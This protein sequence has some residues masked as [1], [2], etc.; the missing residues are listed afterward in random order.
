[1]GHGASAQRRISKQNSNQAQSTETL[2]AHVL[3]DQQQ[4]PGHP[5]AGT[6]RIA[7]AR[8]HKSQLVSC[9]TTNFTCSICG[10]R[11]WVALSAVARQ[12]ATQAAE[13]GEAAALALQIILEQQAGVCRELWR[14][15]H[16]ELNV[17]EA[18][19]ESN[20]Q[21][22]QLH[23]SAASIA[24]ARA[25]LAAA[26]AACDATQ[27]AEALQQAETLGLVETLPDLRSSITKLRLEEEAEAL[28]RC[29]GRALTD[30]DRFEL[31]LWCD[32]AAAQG[33]CVP[34]EVTSALR[35]LQGAEHARLAELGYQADFDSRVAEA[36]GRG[37][38]QL[39][40]ELAS[41][42]RALGADASSAEASLTALHSNSDGKGLPSHQG[43]QPQETPA[44][45]SNEQGS[46]NAEDLRQ[47]DVA[48]LRANLALSGL[49]VSCISDKEELIRLLL[50]TS[51]GQR[52]ERSTIDGTASGSNLGAGMPKYAMPKAAAEARPTA[53]AASAG[54]ATGPTAG[55]REA[56]PNVSAGRPSV[57]GAKATVPGH[58]DAAWR[59]RPPPPPHQPSG[60]GSSARPGAGTPPGKAS[61]APF[62][63]RQKRPDEPW[64]EG[65]QRP[66]AAKI[67]AGPMTR[68]R[69][70][71][72]LGLSGEPDEAEVRRAYKQAALRWHPDRRQNHGRA[73]EAKVRFQEVREA[74]D[75]LRGE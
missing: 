72:C 59:N 51:E 60:G 21:Q 54:D 40:Q 10:A 5:E 11:V 43:A 28:W 55:R 13:R 22:Q 16:E 19:W 1:M 9:G 71:A 52:V 25:L 41:E 66:P 46:L 68:M 32:E 53:A 64:E 27:L 29:L 37:D 63:P 39:L 45:G 20:G 49:D 57:A 3:R 23:T 44:S 67:P 69:A 73:D 17:A 15:V 38:R 62:P 48:S 31:Q 33:L 70:L 50:A 65:A 58:P 36:R 26:A 2:E 34:P 12:A 35:A 74:F 42:A 24:D 7:C 6:A 61:A 30:R 14:Q 56:P 4:A 47:L 18:L 75:F 8:C